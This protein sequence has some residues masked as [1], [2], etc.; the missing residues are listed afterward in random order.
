MGRILNRSDI[1]MDDMGPIS[2]YFTKRDVFILGLLLAFLLQSCKK[3]EFEP[4][5]GGGTLK[6]RSV[7]IADRPFYEYLYNS[8]GTVMEELSKTNSANYNFNEKDQLVAVDY[9]SDKDLLTMDLADLQN[10]L[11]Q[12]GFLNFVSSDMSSTLVYKYDLY[13]QLISTIFS[14][15]SDNFQ[16]SSEFVYDAKGRISRQKLLWNRGIVGYIDYLYDT[17]GNLVKETLYSITSSGLPELS[18]TTQY[19]FDNYYNPFRV[20][21]RLMTPG[22]NTN[23]NNIVRETLTIHFKPGEGTDIVHVTNNT[24]TYNRMGYPVRKN[25]IIEYLYE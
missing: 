24:Y 1:N 9:S 20:L 6:I 21:Y 14:R 10:A 8:A 16:E 4:D 7:I 19:E 23:M 12:K 15:P 11:N 5:F 3:D 18:T 2:F 13:G 25:G 17:G 22:I